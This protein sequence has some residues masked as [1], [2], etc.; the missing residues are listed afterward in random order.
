MGRHSV[1]AGLI[2]LT[3]W[4]CAA[5]QPASQVVNEKLT[6]AERLVSEKRLEEALEAY[7]EVL[8]QDERSTTAYFNIGWIYNEQRKYD[9]ASRWLKKGAQVDPQDARI[10]HEL[11][12]AY[13][14]LQNIEACIQA[15]T[16]ACELKPERI[17]S[18]VGLGDACFEM[19]KD[20]PAAIKAYQ[21]AVDLGSSAAEV[22][23]H[24]GWCYNHQ[25]QPEQGQSCLKRAAEKSPPSAPIWLEWGY[26]L[27]QLKKYDEA[28]Q[29]LTRA[30]VIE[31]KLP[32]GRFYLGRAYLGMGKKQQAKTQL[33][34]LRG[35]DAD[36]ARQ[37]EADF[38]STK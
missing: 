24:L 12:F 37:L 28:S 15:Y 11:G 32:L 4:N 33:Q 36:L 21:K 14:K 2:V 1:I 18:W 20:Y 16:K 8:G 23:Y 9:S 22:L 5:A 3:L 38:R 17:D 30:L 6:T 31:P 26:S 34:E 7:K 27:L 10:Q 25:G 35:L 13:S 19:K 29:A